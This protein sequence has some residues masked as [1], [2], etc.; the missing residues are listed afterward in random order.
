VYVS[1]SGAVALA[2]QDDGMPS[3]WWRAMDWLRERT[4]EPFG[5]P[6]FYHARYT[7][8]D[9]TR[10]P[11]YSVMSWWDYG[12]WIIRLGR[13]VPVSNPT[14][15]GAAESAGFLVATTEADA[16]SG[17]DRANARYVVVDDDLAFRG[18]GSAPLAGRFEAVAD[19]SSQPRS[20]FYQR[21]FERNA[22]GALVPVWLFYPAYYR[23]MAVRMVAYG[24][25]AAEPAG[26]SYVI[27]Y[28]QRTDAQGRG[29]REILE[30]KAFATYPEAEAYLS[31]LGPGPH[32]LVG[33]DPRRTC[34]PVEAL[35]R[36][37]LR[38]RESAVIP[39]GRGVPTVSIFERVRSAQARR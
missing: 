14:R 23:T 5:T 26:S 19:W 30:S 18:G 15:S 22:R 35:A 9:A 39:R 16:L 21:Y 34:V 31:S 27:T 38:D 2:R 36:L 1:L 12:Y 7:A 6:G 28:A 29:F 13:R 3:T 37:R 4:P 10:M 8:A 33:R 20:R 24:G 11:A 32:R 17:L 25:G